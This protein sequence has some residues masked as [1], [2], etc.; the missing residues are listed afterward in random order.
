MDQLIQA[1]IGKANDQLAAQGNKPG[2]A[3]PVGD[4]AADQAAMMPETYANPT[5]QHM[6]E[7]LATLPKRAIDASAAD[8]AHYSQHGMDADYVPQ[9]IG[10]ATETAMTLMGT[11]MPMAEAGAAG[12]FGGRLAKTADLRALTEA[13]NM[14]A[15][16]LHPDQVFRDTGWFR[17][18]ADSKWRFEIPDNKMQLKYM[19]ETEGHDVI[20]DVGSLVKHD[21]LFKAYPDLQFVKAGIV[22]DDLTPSG[23]GMFYPSEGAG[24]P[25]KIGVSA[26]DAFTARSVMAHELMHG[27][28]AKEGFAF[29]ADPSYIARLIETG[30]RKNPDILGGN[31]LQDVIPEAGNLYHKMAGEVEPRNVQER[32]LYNEIE[33]KAAPPWYTQDVP[34]GQQFNWG[35][36][37]EIYPLRPKK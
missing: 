21:A 27:V 10:P 13:E 15:H 25:P 5:V 31:K 7:A 2:G 18:P 37:G 20:G 29:G 8:V 23:M 1:L 36:S 28:Q 3:A 11:G 34:Y 16:G 6:V 19:P 12:I 35:P 24:M 9:T 33:R 4:P 30:I 26:P 22:K 17:S 32:L 14:A